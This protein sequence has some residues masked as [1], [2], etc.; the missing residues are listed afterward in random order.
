MGYSISEA[1][2][3]KL[4]KNRREGRLCCGATAARYGC[5]T[6]ATIEA[7]QES[8]AY[9]LDEGEGLALKSRYCARHLPRED[10]VNFRVIAARRLA[11]HE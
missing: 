9:R 1:T 8:F 4:E 11:A 6:R 7:T 2:H 3:R 10:G 5:L